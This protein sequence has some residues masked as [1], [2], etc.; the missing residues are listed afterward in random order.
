MNARPTACAVIIPAH[1]EAATLPATLRSLRAAA[2]H[3]AM[4]G[5]P[6]LTVVAVDACTDDTAA[7]ARSMGAR[8]VESARR[9]VGIARAMAAE[10][11]LRLLRPYEQG[12]WIAT[13]DA[14][15]IVPVDWLA[16]Q[17]HH[18]GEGWECLV[19]TVRL[20]PHPLLHPAV[21]AKHDAQYFAG[22]PAGPVLWTH[23]HIHGANLGVTAGAYRGAGGFPPLAH[24]EDR[25]LVTALQRQHRRIL[26]TD[27]CPVLTS[28]RPDHRAPHGLGA[29]LNVLAQAPGSRTDSG[30]SP[31]DGATVPEP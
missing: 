6:L 2:A 11:A 30:D 16:H 19:G 9:N 26:R 7:V 13:T 21:V 20:A 28:S 15:T 10:E 1:N 22:R 27:R 14:D 24:S 18:A 4:P 17:L 5:I 29:A 31:R 25:A 23:P 12:L 8:V 3:R